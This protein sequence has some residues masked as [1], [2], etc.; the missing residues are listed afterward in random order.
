L[1]PLILSQRKAFQT[2]INNACSE[3]AGDAV[4]NP[5][6]QSELNVM[7]KSFSGQAV[8]ALIF[9]S[10]IASAEPIKLK[11]AFQTSDRAYTY[12]A[13]IKPFVDAVNREAKELLEIKV[14]FSGSLGKTPSQW[15]T[16]RDGAADIAFV[17][18]GQAGDRFRDAEIIE[19][20]GLFRTM[21]EATLTFTRLVAT[22]RLK[23]FDDFYVIGAFAVDP[24]TIHIRQPVASLS[25]LRGRK[26]RV[27]NS[28]LAD[29]LGKLGMK[30]VVMSVNLTADAISSGQI[31]G[32]AIPVGPLTEFGIGRIATYHYFLPLSSAP[33]AL[34]MDSKRFASLPPR[35]QEILRKYSGDWFAEQYIAILETTNSKLMEQLKSDSRRK[36]IFPS[37]ADLASAQVVFR[38]VIDKWAAID[39]SHGDLLKSVEAE[40]AKIR[41]TP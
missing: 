13:A 37:Q 5:P 14:Y 2:Y 19:L 27:N 15:E 34:L 10:G 3:G 29:T 22:H 16:I 12:E 9:A 28:T 25:D 31:D 4:A 24:E 36:V 23:D 41:S 8:A 20:L 17:I 30:G 18:L 26:I 7:I 32:A 38:S 11:L 6:L 1:N 33:F 21:R 35:A 39:P 40:L